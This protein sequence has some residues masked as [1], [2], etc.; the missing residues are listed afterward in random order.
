MRAFKLFL[1]LL[2]LMIFTFTACTGGNQTTPAP[3]TPQPTP[4]TP[5]PPTVK[6]KDVVLVF[7]DK[8]LMGQY[9]ETRR[10]QY[11]DEADLPKLALEEWQKGPVNTKLQSIIPKDVKFLS[12]TKENNGAVLNFSAE[13]K[14]ANL[15]STGEGFLLQETAT[16]LSQFGYQTTRFLIDGKQVETILGHMDATKPIKP[17][18]LNTIKEMK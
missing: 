4:T 15:G 8:E 10:I 3:Q 7:P 6:E 17:L 1:P 11:T 12:I 16:I 9:K 18:D 13:I 2:L 14:K 5:T